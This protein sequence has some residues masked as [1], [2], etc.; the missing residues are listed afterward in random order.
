MNYLPDKETTFEKKVQTAEENL[1]SLMKNMSFASSSLLR[2]KSNI[3]C[4]PKLIA[5]SS[6]LSMTFILSLE[7]FTVHLT[8]RKY[9]FDIPVVT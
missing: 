8:K 9:Y 7:F 2:R 3:V 4:V 1:F 6:L 5:S